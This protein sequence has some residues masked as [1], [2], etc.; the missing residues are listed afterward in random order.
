MSRLTQSTPHADSISEAILHEIYAI[1]KL[2]EEKNT[3]FPPDMIRIR[4]E[5]D[6]DTMLQEP[7]M[8]ERKDSIAHYCR[9][10]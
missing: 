4:E 10:Y 3:E 5:Q 1:N 2:Q 8:H 9:R 6:Q 7:S